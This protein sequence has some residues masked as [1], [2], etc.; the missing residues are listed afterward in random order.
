MRNGKVVKTASALAL[1]IA[2]IVLCVTPAMA[3]PSISSKWGAFYGPWPVTVVITDCKR[4]NLRSTPQLGVSWNVVAY[5]PQGTQLT[6]VGREGNF[7]VLQ[8]NG[9]TVY[10]YAAYL[11]P[12]KALPQP[13]P[14]PQPPVVVVPWR[15]IT[16]TVP[17]YPPYYRPQ[18]PTQPQRPSRPGPFRPN[19]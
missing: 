3:E 19:R 18:Y 17:V 9:Q 16:P 5:P 12:V 11:S 15:P 8:Y 10:G 2:L 4:L 13:T 7:V 14:Q 1:L 6:A